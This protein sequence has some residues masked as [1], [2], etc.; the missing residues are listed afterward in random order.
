MAVLGQLR[1]RPETP[2][3]PAL[4]ERCR[5]CLRLEERQHARLVIASRQRR[6]IDPS[7]A[8]ALTASADASARERDI[9]ARRGTRRLRSPTEPLPKRATSESGAEHATTS[10]SPIGKR[11]RLFFWRTAKPRTAP[12]A[13]SPGPSAD[14]SSLRPEPNLK[15]A[16]ADVDVSLVTSREAPPRDRRTHQA[17]TRPGWLSRRS[18]ISA[19]AASLGAFA[20]LSPA[21]KAVP[22]W[23][24]PANLSEAGQEAASPQVAFDPQ[25]DTVAVWRRFSGS[26][27]IVQA[28]VR[29]VTS[30]TWQTP[31][32]LSEPGRDATEPHVAFDSS[33]NAIAIWKRSNGANLIIQAAARPA[34]SGTWGTPVNLSEAGQNAANPHVAFDSQGNAIAVWNRENGSNQIVQGSVR[35]ASSGTWQTPVSISETGWNSF[36]PQLAVDPAG[37]A[38]AVWRRTNGISGEFIQAAVRPV[39]SGTWQAPVRLSE[40]GQN[41]EGPQVAFD[42]EGNTLALWQRYNGSAYIV[43]SSVRPVSSGTWQ[44]PVNVSEGGQNAINPQ[45]AFDSQGDAIAVWRRNNGSN[46]IAQAAVRPV[47]SGT[48]Q[49]PVS[50]SEVGQSAA[51]PLVA[52]DSAGDAVAAWSRSNGANNIVQASARPVSSGTWQAPVNLSEAGQAAIQPQ[53]AIDPDGDAIAAWRRSNGANNIVQAAGYGSAGP[54]LNEVTIPTS[55]TAGQA[56]S[57]S[58]SPL[59]VW[60]S[61]GETRWSFGDGQSASGASVTHAYASPGFYEVSVTNTDGLGN[62]TTRKGAVV[63]GVSQVKEES[64]QTQAHASGTAVGTASSHARPSFELLSKAPRPLINAQSLRVRAFC[65]AGVCSISGK[66]SVRLPGRRRALRLVSTTVA[67][68]A[69]RAGN[70]LFLVPKSVRGAVR[71]YLQHHPRYKVKIDLSLSLLSG[72]QV[73]QTVNATLAIWTYPRFR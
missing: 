66:A 44:T 40:T 42:H 14:P 62:T 34:S 23:L 70:L 20:L 52:M 63:V 33:G 15:A 49:T 69:G 31:V 47:S 25:G 35:P 28:S 71:S 27:E 46:Y 11:T 50:L 16:C 21:A 7:A 10:K 29:P 56:I 18:A 3:S 32:N 67:I 5:E 58:V 61:L 48:W 43:Q 65:S 39:S 36:E 64:P 57:F 68:A 17:P 4:Q 8:D 19:L 41:A 53:L 54:R 59:D 38:V 2:I 60:A 6:Q 73:S 9:V 1:Q 12:L 37:D 72:T 22:T 55:G 45:L 51:E 24:S 30:G 13:R 26:N